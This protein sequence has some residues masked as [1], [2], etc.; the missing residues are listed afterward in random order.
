MI[1]EHDFFFVS[2]RSTGIPP[3]PIFLERKIARLETPGRISRNTVPL[4]THKSWF[5][6]PL[7]S[8]KQTETVFS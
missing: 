8:R 4:A 5:D 6:S 7:Q 2:S 3:P 1:E